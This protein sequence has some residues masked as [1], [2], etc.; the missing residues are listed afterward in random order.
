[1]SGLTDNFVISEA[2]ELAEEGKRAARSAYAKAHPAIP[3]SR[4]TENQQSV[5]YCVYVGGMMDA[6]GFVKKELVAGAGKKGGKP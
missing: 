2:G 3:F 4:L 1:M 6:L 5:I